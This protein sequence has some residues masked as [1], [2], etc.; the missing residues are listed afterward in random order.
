[1]F[2]F[3]FGETDYPRLP[4]ARVQLSQE[5]VEIVDHGGQAL[6]LG[7]RQVGPFERVLADMEEFGRRG[8]WVADGPCSRLLA[9]RRRSAR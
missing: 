5:Q 2:L 9:A 1:M 6:R 8:I 7:A 4:T 3:L